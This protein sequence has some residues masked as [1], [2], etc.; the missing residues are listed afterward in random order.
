MGVPPSQAVEQVLRKLRRDRSFMKNVA[1]WHKV[2]PRPAQFGERPAG[3]DDE[4]F[5][6]LKRQGT[7]PLYSHQSQAIEAA[8]RGENVVVVTGTA[9]GKTLCYNLPTLQILRDDPGGSALYLFPTKALAQD[10]LAGLRTMLDVLGDGD[11]KAT[12]PTLNLYDGDTPASRRTAIRKAGGVLL[13]NPDMLHAGILPHHTRWARFFSRLRVVVLDEIHSYRGVFGSH[14]ANLMRRLRRICKLYGVDPLFIC[15]SATI[16]NPAEHAQRLIEAPVTLIPADQDGSPRGARHFILYNPPLLDASLGLRQSARIA[17]VEIAAEF[18]REDVQTVLFARS[19]LATE[20]LLTTLREELAPETVPADRLQGYRGGYL[21][22]ERR[23][24]ERGL[25]DGSVRGVAATNALELGVDIGE[26]SACLMSGYPGT[27]ASTRQQAGRAG[28]NLESAV[29]VLVATAYPLDQYIMTHPRYLFD[30]SP[31]RALINPDNLV[32][33]VKHLQCASYELPFERG[34]V[35]GSAGAIDEILDFLVEEGFLHRGDRAYH[36]VADDYPAASVSLRS[37]GSETIV[38]QDISEGERPAVIGQ[39]ERESAPFLLYEG[40]IYPHRG[41]SYLVEKLDWEGARADVRPVSV[42]YTTR[43]SSSSTLRILEV[44]ES[45]PAGPVQKGHGRVQVT[46]QVSAYRKIKRSTHEILGWGDVDL[47]PQVLETTAYWFSVDSALAGRLEAAGILPGS[48]DYGPNWDQQKRAALARDGERCQHC[49][50]G[51]R[52]G[53]R[54]DVH[55]IKPFR[56]FGYRQGV[57]GAYLQANALDNLITLCSSCHRRA[58]GEVRMRSS[59]A[60]LGS[61]LRNL[62][63]L[64]LMCDAR[65]IFVLS[66][67]EAGGGSGPTVTIYERVP[68]GVGFSQQ[69]YELH[70]ELLTAA[71]DLIQACPCRDGCPACVGP[72]GQIP[73]GMGLSTKGATLLLLEAVREEAGSTLSEDGGG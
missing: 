59:L 32:I 31:E 71:A 17:S 27:I 67:V 21:P 39:V 57:N 19:R 49:G 8:L 52:P 41:V 2:P 6:L 35:Y 26:L 20:L 58:E 9:S 66:D 1:A 61:L 72:A 50:A 55:H 73:V 30:R 68:A 51:Q 37:G 45:A 43:A 38:I 23:A 70:N 22:R 33:L 40:A 16:A 34:E 18:L 48:I 13:S 14:L 47:P 62:A 46:S 69:L 5:D 56:T 25:R 4:L 28:R 10:Q 44:H 53:R 11:P 65:D 24:I 63:P 60:G 54:H 15:T 7:W 29:A 42:E 12:Q 64:Y 36:W 3:L